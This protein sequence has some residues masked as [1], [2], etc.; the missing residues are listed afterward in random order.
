MDITMLNRSFMLQTGFGL[1]AL[2]LVIMQACFDSSFRLRVA[3]YFLLFVLLQRSAL[4][5]LIESLILV[6]QFI[7]P[8]LTFTATAAN[9]VNILSASSKESG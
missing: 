8:L 7:P 2:L 5:L 1:Y 9:T 6:S 4:S 3:A